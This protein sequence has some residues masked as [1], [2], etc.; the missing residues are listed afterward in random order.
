MESESAL[1]SE[2]DR[3]PLL[4]FPRREIPGHKR[5]FRR[6]SVHADVVR[7]CQGPGELLKFFDN[8]LWM[9]MTKALNGVVYEK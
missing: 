4:R 6:M 5:F 8:L 3:L 7:S 2:Q 9:D 1:V